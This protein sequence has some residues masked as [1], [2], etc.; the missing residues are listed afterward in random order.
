MPSRSRQ[1][2]TEEQRR[3]LRRKALARLSN[4]QGELERSLGAC[5][6]FPRYLTPVRHRDRLNHALDMLKLAGEDVP[7]W[8]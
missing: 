3:A 2:L 5:N 7:P 4:F 6:A 8:L 1:P